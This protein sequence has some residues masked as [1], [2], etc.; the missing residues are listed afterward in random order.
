[1]E[2]LFKFIRIR[3]DEQKYIHIKLFV[4]QNKFEIDRE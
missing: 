3:V 2:S 4:L 1:M